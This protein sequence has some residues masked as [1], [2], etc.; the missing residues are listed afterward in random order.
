MSNRIQKAISTIAVAIIVIII[1][2]AAGIG[3]YVATRTTT[4]TT[5]TSSS[6]TSTTTSATSSTSSLTSTTSSSSV[7]LVAC[8]TMTLVFCFPTIGK[9]SNATLTSNET[10]TIGVLTD[11]TSELASIGV[12]IGYAAQL[13]AAN[14]DKWLHANDTS[15]GNLNFTTD[16]LNYALNTQ[17]A[18]TDLSTLSTEGVTV[19]VGPLDSGTLGN[20]YST[21]ASDHIVLIS[22]SSTS[23]LLAGISPYVYRTVPNDAFQGLAD[24]R[25]MYQDGV[26]NL[27]IV[28]TDTAY[29]SGLANATAARFRALGGNVTTEIPYPSTTTDFTTVLSTLSSAWSTATTNAGGNAS[30]VAIQAI[31]Y[32]E[33]GALLQQASTQDPALLKTAQPWYGTDGE[34]ANSAF[35]NSTYAS[36]S[37][38]VRLPS[39]LYAPTNTSATNSI[40]MEIDAGSPGGCSAYALAAY[41]NTWLAAEAILQCGE[42]NGACLTTA[43]GQVANESVGVTGPMT[44]GSN[45]DRV[46]NEY[47]IYDIVTIS[48]TVQWVIAGNWTVTSDIVSWNSYRPSY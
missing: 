26:R 48:G 12:G 9:G 3:V 10:I 38:D 33:I 29:G 43:I 1:I 23:V 40:C 42:N 2:V 22:P 8:N 35:T 15:W 4:T 45:H 41:D 13:G 25:E 46:A 16:V 47:D 37:A 31:G 32:Q 14:F 6:T 5:T 36:Y 17:T 44:L 34:S 19:A 27:I 21:A 28:Y 39:T 24:A 7:Q 18:M 11:E 30:S 20:I